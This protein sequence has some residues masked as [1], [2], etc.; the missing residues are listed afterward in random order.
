[1]TK[2]CG[3]ALIHIL[4]DVVELGYKAP[5]LEVWVMD[6]IRCLAGLLRVF[7]WDAETTAF[8]GRILQCLPRLLSESAA[9]LGFEFHL[10]SLAILRARPVLCKPELS[11]CKLSLSFTGNFLNNILQVLP[12]LCGIASEEAEAEDGF[13]YS[14][15]FMTVI[16][17]L[18]CHATDEYLEH[19]RFALFIEG[20]EGLVDNFQRSTNRLSTG[21]L[22]TLQ[23]CL[24]RARELDQSHPGLVVTC[25]V[26][27]WRCLR[28][29]SRRPGGRSYC[30]VPTYRP[31]FYVL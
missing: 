23:S 18:A 26:S 24:D 11:S 20:A 6:A 15:Q 8:D 9:S 28:L 3:E 12:G 22:A 21:D 29:D 4:V 5:G 10:H 19:G 30:S 7:N 2:R 27:S 31:I 16:L 1:M 25:V 14:L 13:S 17:T